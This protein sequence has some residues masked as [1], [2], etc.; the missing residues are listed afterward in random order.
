MNTMNVIQRSK[1]RESSELFNK[2]EHLD[3]LFLF[4]TAILFSL[5]DIL[6]TILCIEKNGYG[7]EGNVFIREIIHTTGVLGFVIVKFCL[8]LFA[9]LITYSII[10]HRNFFGW[11]NVKMFYG[12]YVGSIISSIFVTV[13][14]LS[15]IYAGSSLYFLNLDP[16]QIAVILLFTA[17]LTG[18]FLDTINNQKKTLRPQNYADIR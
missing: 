3:N 17:P 2:V 15:V 14:N 4:S 11:K 13:S 6:S 5:T 8:A 16:Y 12:I 18:F 7:Y 9:L 10:E 1:N